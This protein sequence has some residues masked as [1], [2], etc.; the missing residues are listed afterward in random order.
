MAP[1]GSNQK[2]REHRWRVLIGSVALG[3]AA[4][5]LSGSGIAT[6]S[7]GDPSSTVVVECNSGIVTQGDV[8]TSS[9]FVAKVPADQLPDTP[10]GCTV[11][12]G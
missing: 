10:G 1:R 2:V 9:L 4:L 6:A 8:Q 11:K 5:G 3:V 12:T 7:T